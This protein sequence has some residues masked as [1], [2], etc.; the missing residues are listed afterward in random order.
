[1]S[2]AR[3]VSR[4]AAGWSWACLAV[5][6][7]FLVAALFAFVVGRVHFS[8][9]CSAFT[10]ACLRSGRAGG[11]REGVAARAGSELCVS[12]LAVWRTGWRVHLVCRVFGF[13][14][15]VCYGVGVAA[16]FTW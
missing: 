3:R 9:A 16:I 1:M 13:S 8:V 11:G 7:S 2:E 15:G 5:D 10:V 4:A 12:V 6:L 14:V